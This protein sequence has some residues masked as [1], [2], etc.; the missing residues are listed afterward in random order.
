MTIFKLKDNDEVISA[1]LNDGVVYIITENGFAL[2][3][4]KEEIPVV[5]LKTSGVKGIKLVNGKVVSGFVTND[6][7]EYITIFF[8]ESA[9]PVL[10]LSII[11]MSLDL[12]NSPVPSI[13]P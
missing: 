6:N 7:H 4:S 13:S 3:F 10:D 1:S 11:L 12:I 8:L 2:K 5:G 9:L